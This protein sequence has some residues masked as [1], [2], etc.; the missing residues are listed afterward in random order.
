MPV[1]GIRGATVVAHDRAEEV[2]AA[3]REL[4]EAIVAANKIVPDDVASVIFTVT[5][6]LRSEYPARAARTMGWT[7][8][9]LLGATEMAVPGGLP[10]C[11]RVLLHVNSD[12]SPREI[13]HIYLHEAAMLRRDR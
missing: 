4:L 13:K 11:I 3:T 6:D 8:V 2:I 12:R 7:D 5:P 9:A 10:R 1:R